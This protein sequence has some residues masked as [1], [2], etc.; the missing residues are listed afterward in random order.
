MVQRQ[1]RLQGLGRGRPLQQL[2][3]GDQAGQQRVVDAR[4]LGGDAP[5]GRGGRGTAASG[6]RGGDGAAAAC[7][8]ATAAPVRRAAGRRRPRRAVPRRA[9]PHPGGPG[10]AE[11][12]SA[13]RPFGPRRIGCAISV[14]SPAAR[15]VMDHHAVILRLTD[16]LQSEPARATSDRAA[17]SGG[18]SIQGRS[19]LRQGMHRRAFP[20]PPEVQLGVRSEP[21]A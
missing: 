1:A 17:C 13:P 10:S 15:P 18:R 20:P 12:A 2:A 7:P 8:A 3:E 14:R 16:L 6:R 5:A 9:E 21:A 19:R 11:G 4:R